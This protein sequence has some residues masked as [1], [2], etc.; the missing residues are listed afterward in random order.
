MLKSEFK[1]KKGSKDRNPLLFILPD[2]L[3]INDPAHDLVEVTNLDEPGENV[4]ASGISVVACVGLVLLTV[5]QEFLVGVDRRVRGF[6]ESSD[7]CGGFRGN[8]VYG[9]AVEKENNFNLL[10]SGSMTFGDNICLHKKV[11]H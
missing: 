3:F 4:S 2:A 10:W 7:G 9:G 1:K 5:L 6:P 11:I 8:P